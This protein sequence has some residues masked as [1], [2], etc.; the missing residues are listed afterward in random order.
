MPDSMFG[1]AMSHCSLL[2]LIGSSQIRRVRLPRVADAD[3]NV[4]YDELVGLCVT[5]TFPEGSPENYEVSLTYFDVDEDTV[6]IASSDE[7]IDAISQ[8]AEQKILRVS[9]EVKPKTKAY[10]KR[11]W[12]LYSA[13]QARR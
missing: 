11:D 4:S 13:I 12:N 6:T 10:A 5:F 3:G 2:R 9:T 8:Y 7:L 1:L